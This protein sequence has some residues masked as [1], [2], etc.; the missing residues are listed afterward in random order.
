M[1]KCIAPSFRKPALADGE[2]VRCR[3]KTH[4]RIVMASQ[5]NIGYLKVI[6]GLE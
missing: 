6:V 3:P 4:P 1:R 2:A 5:G